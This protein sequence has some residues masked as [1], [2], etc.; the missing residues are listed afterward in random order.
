MVRSSLLWNAI[1]TVS[2]GLVVVLAATTGASSIAR[3][4]GEP[5]SI[6]AKLSQGA[7]PP[8]LQLEGI[9]DGRKRDRYAIQGKLRGL[10]CS[11]KTYRLVVASSVGPPGSSYDATMVLRRSGGDNVRCG[12]QLPRKLGR[13]LARLQV[14]G[15]NATPAD[16]VIIVSG[17]RIGTTKIKGLFTTRELLCDRTYKLRMQLSA[18]SGRLSMLYDVSMKKVSI[19]GR[20]CI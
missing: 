11:G 17:R 3:S 1:S 5:I 14:Y 15:A 18:P 16:S 13:A 4:A 12:A 9:Q 19:N 20:R 10:P 8:L 2:A 6:H 7:D